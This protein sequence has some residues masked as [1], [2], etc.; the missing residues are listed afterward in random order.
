MDAIDFLTNLS[1]LN[2]QFQPIFSADE[3][4]VVAY[5]ARGEILI[6]GELHTIQP[7]IEDEDIPIEYR[8]DMELQFMKKALFAF[9]NFDEEVS[10]FLAC[11][12]TLLMEAYGEKHLAVLRTY[13]IDE[14]LGR[15][16]IETTERLEGQQV[17]QLQHV[18]KY[19]KTYGIKIAI[20]EVGSESHIEHVTQLE[21]NVL[22]ISIAQLPYESWASQMDMIA[23]IGMIAHKI[24]ASLF[25]TGIDTIYQLQF[26]W[27]NGGRYYQGSYLADYHYAP[28]VKDVHKARFKEDCQSFISSEK[29]LIER[30]LDAL[31]AVEEQLT[32]VIKQTRLVDDKVSYLEALGKPLIDCAFRM[33]ICN[34]DGFQTT[35]NVILQEGIWHVNYEAEQKNWSWRPYFLETLV[36][37]RKENECVISAPYSDI[38]TGELTRTFSTRMNDSEF[39]F[40]DLRHNYIFKHDLI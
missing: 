31:Q 1:E 40:I 35:P 28:I 36:K 20:A 22:K 38:E 29:K 6:D 39:L 23:A 2:V 8:L 10:L 19:F 7:F 21:P 18:L 3:H 5:E 11:H 24:G 4:I 15:I 25:F 34:E 32:N 12:S 33:Y 17:E 27:R 37:M 13:L 9:Q 30:K 16:V 26:A 14:E